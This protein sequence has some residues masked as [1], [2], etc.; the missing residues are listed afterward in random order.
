MTDN[1]M[2][3]TTHLTSQGIRH[4]RTPPYTHQSNEVAERYNRTIQTMVRSML[5]DLKPADNFLW[6]EACSVAV[7]IRNRLPHSQLKQRRD[8]TPA[9]EKTPFEMLHNKQP[10]I[11]HL[12]P[13]G[14]LCYIHIPE[15]KRSAGSKLQPRAERAT[16]VGY[17]ESP[18]IY[19]VQLANKQIFT[20]H[21]RGC[22]FM[23]PPVQQA[24]ENGKCAWM[25]R[26]IYGLK[27]SPRQWYQRLTRFLI[28]LGFVTA[29]F[30]PCV[31]IH[32]DNQVIIAIYVDDITIAGPNTAKRED[33]K[34]LLQAAFQLS[35]LGPLDWLL[36]IQIQWRDDNNSVTLS[37]QTYIDQILLRFQMDTCN[38]VHLPL[39]PNIKLLK[40][41]GSDC[42][43]TSYE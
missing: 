36:G 37:Q 29:Y 42:K 14:S 30:D 40:A 28:P 23:Q 33:L 25:N 12:Q 18:N 22:A 20:I 21:A 1:S 11:S 32:V 17:T 4:I 34:K 19:K 41:Q 8:N 2:E 13:F 26:S 10:S 31:L 35:D 24:H 3:A 16:F 27:Q 6:A 39:N 43:N 15:E 9:Q 7:Y 38:P 5:I